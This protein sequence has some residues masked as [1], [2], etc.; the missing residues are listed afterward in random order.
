VALRKNRRYGGT[1]SLHLRGE[2]TLESS[3]FS[4]RLY[5]TTEGGR[6]PLATAPP[7][8]RL[9]VTVELTVNVPLLRRLCH[10]L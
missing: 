2:N 8:S 4:A 9:P 5:L 6:E 10:S 3:Q 1:Y 7:A